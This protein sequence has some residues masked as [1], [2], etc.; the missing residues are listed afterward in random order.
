MKHLIYLASPYSHADGATMAGRFRAVC[1]AASR[2]MRDGHLIFSPIAHSHPIAMRTALPTDWTYWQQFDRAILAACGEL[3]V[4]T[5]EGW[6]ASQG[7]QAEVA[8]AMQMGLAV[9]Y[10]DPDT[11][12]VRP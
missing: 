11:L 10:V 3:W 12:E 8:L 9:R 1:D 4:L 5:L 6:D 7:V 2:L